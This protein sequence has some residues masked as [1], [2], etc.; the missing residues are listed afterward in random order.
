MTRTAIHQL[1]IVAAVGAAFVLW[2]LLLAYGASPAQAAT[3]TVNSLADTTADDGQCTLREAITAANTDNASGLL[4]E[5]ARRAP[6]AT[7]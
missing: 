6:G 2:G 3:I 5:S 4:R 7:L 1:K